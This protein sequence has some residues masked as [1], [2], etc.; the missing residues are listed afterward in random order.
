MQSI[1]NALIT[2]FAPS[3]IAVRLLSMMGQHI[4]PSVKIGFSWIQCKHIDLK[5]NCKIGNFNLIRIS[6]LKMDKD[7][8]I[9]NFNR[10]KG[11]MSLLLAS[12]AAIGNSNN[13][14]RGP[15]PITHGKAHLKLG[16]LAIITS[17]HDID[18]TRSI[19][20][21]NNTTISGFGCQLWTHGFYHADKGEYRI[22]I[23]GSIKIGNNV[24]I[25]SRCLINPGVSIGDAINV[26]SNTCISKSI[27]K[28]GMYVS[29]GLRFIPNNIEIIQS[30]LKKDINNQYVEVYTK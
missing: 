15:F 28:S 23:D 5:A 1:F 19:E 9:R 6:K 3:W 30:K 13:I 20:I 10:M 18:C 17:K 2:F 26:G 24:S 4:H 21:G 16:R 12:K 29:Q 7:A 14:Y 22:R 27:Y 8:S 11:P 25:G